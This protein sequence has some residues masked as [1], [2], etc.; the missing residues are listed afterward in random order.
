MRGFI[1][2]ILSIILKN[3]NNLDKILTIT[4]TKKMTELLSIKILKKRESHSS[5]QTFHYSDNMN[6][7]GTDFNEL[8]TIF[9]KKQVK[10]S[11]K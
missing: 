5:I 10:R 1:T 7:I 9:M 2:E 4:T 8:H 3:F 6:Q 11:F